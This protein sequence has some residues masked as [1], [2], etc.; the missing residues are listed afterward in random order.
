MHKTYMVITHLHTVYYCART[1]ILKC[2]YVKLF[3]FI[4][5]SKK[6]IDLLKFRE[7]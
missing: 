2:K 1:G 6:G 7:L 3:Y 5:N 4:K